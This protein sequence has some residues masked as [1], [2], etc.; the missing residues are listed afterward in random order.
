MS[1]YAGELDCCGP[2]FACPNAAIRMDNATSYLDDVMARTPTCVPRDPCVFFGC[3][4]SFVTCRTGTCQLTKGSPDA[5][6]ALTASDYARTCQEVADCIAVY[7]GP[8]GCCGG[9][10]PN[11]AI[12]AA[13]ANDYARDVNRRSPQCSQVIPCPPVSPVCPGGR[14]ACQDGLCVLH[15]PPAAAK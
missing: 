5:S 7:E 12:S 9:S 13:A 3:S 2:A 4:Q 14:I 8:L 11:A 15:T 6:L 1:I 10:C